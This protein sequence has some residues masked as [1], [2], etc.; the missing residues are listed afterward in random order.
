MDLSLVIP[1]YNEKEN[2]EILFS[3]IQEE[4]LKNKIDGEVVFVDDGSPDG[5]GDIL[6]ILEK[7]NKNLKVIHRSGKLG[8][9]SAVVEG[10]KISSGKIVGVMDADLSHPADKIHEL[11]YSIRNNNCDLAIGSRYVRKGK[12]VGWNF[13][14]KLM[15]KT[16]TLFAKPFTKVRDPMAGFFMIKKE[17][18]DFNRINSKGF[19]ILL[20]IILKA[21]Y[22]RVEEI[23]ITFADRTKGKSKAGNSEI[24]DYVNNLIGYKK[25]LR[26]G[27]KQFFK[28]SVVGLSGTIVNLLV[29]YS[30]TEF[31]GTY[32]LLSAFFAF[33]VAVINNFIWNKVW[34]FKEK[35]HYKA[36]VKFGKFLFVSVVALG[37]NLAFLYLFT[38]VFG[39]YY[40]VSQVFSIL[41]SLIINFFGNKFWTFRR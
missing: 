22:K 27:I 13:K 2:V 4:F 38:D 21:N 36:I 37:V 19:K 5:T 20:E 6:E 25:Y 23:P 3:K 17:C 34:T 32:Y 33:I 11:F 35:A 18:I 26:K 10:W 40:L 1:T 31:A 24:F 28:F 15:S 41:I 16:A 8:L 12:I 14:R 30:L 29:L 7:K 9:S 39:I